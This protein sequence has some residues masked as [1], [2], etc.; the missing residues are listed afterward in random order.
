M[1]RRVIFL[2]LPDVELL[3]LAG[4]AQ[5][6]STANSYGAHYTLAY[7]GQA[8]KIKSAQGL[9]LHVCTDFPVIEK[10]N[11]V[12]IPGS[13][14]APMTPMSNTVV[15]WLQTARNE[16]ADIASIC[17]GAFLLGAAGLLNGRRCTTHWS[18][19][20]E[21]ARRYPL[22]KVQEAALYIQDGPINT[23]A[24][25][26]SG[27]D[28][29][30]SL[31][32]AEHGP[33]VTS[34]VAREMVV[35]LRRDGTHRQTSVYLEYRTHLHQGVHR[36]QDWLLGHFAESFDLNELSRIGGLSGRHLSRQ[37]KSATGLTPFEYRQQLR[38]E[39]ASSLIQDPHLTMEN[40][41]H[42]CGFEDARSLRRIWNRTHK[43]S[44]SVTR[45]RTVS[46]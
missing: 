41:A 32:E 24:G 46:R 25:I 38:I 30:L 33:I 31:I 42:R 22:A 44:P 20:Q 23:S 17:S 3:D 27:I 29:A 7:F 37:F 19:T 21:L 1:G 43:H 28:M 14:Q 16:G 40:I 13:R 34:R 35:Y 5:V 36:V 10:G 2:L 39:F 4:P 6:F 26:S 11:L 18:L 45:N 9:N 8:A 12:L 15:R